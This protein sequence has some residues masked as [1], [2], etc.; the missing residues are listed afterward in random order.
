MKPA[1]FIVWT[2]IA[3]FAAPGSA[4]AWENFYDWKR[5]PDRS[6]AWAKHVV[7]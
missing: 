7:G 4:H 1:I 2:V 5:T 6:V 3:L